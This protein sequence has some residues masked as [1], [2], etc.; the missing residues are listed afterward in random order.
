AEVDRGLVGPRRGG[1]QQESG[2]GRRGEGAHGR[3]PRKGGE[4]SGASRRWQASQ[5][6]GLVASAAT[7]DDVAMQLELHPD[8]A[9]VVLIP[10]EG[11]DPAD[12]EDR[13][14]DVV[15]AGR[16]GRPKGE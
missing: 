15:A 11:D 10:E 8:F 5:P 4:P 9:A 12:L 14:H 1:E 13:I 2:Q 6:A 7:G 16:K 3:S